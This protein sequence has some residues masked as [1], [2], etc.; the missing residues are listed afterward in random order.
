RG[1][2]PGPL[3]TRAGAARP[4]RPAGGGVPARPS[5]PVRSAPKAADAP[6]AR[7]A[8]QAPAAAVSHQRE[9]GAGEKGRIA[10][11]NR[12]FSSPLA[13]RLAKEAGIDLARVEGSGP[14]GRVIACEVEAAQ[15]GRGFASPAPA[16]G[17]GARAPA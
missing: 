11:T 16:G 8:P 4:R 9:E 12:V 6:S 13:R 17:A 14:H 5:T 3:V 10:H 1:V 15:A 7:A 2:N